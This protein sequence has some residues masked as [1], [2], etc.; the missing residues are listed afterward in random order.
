MKHGSGRMKAPGKLSKK[1]TVGFFSCAKTLENPCKSLKCKEKMAM[2]RYVLICC[3][4]LQFDP[5]AV[6]SSTNK[7]SK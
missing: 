5:Q 2:A 4:Q 7:G 1:L 6:L 3:R